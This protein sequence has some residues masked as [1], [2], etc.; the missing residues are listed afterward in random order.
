M[1]MNTLRYVVVFVA[2]LGASAA[3]ATTPVAAAAPQVAEQ[4]ILQRDTV[5]VSADL[6]RL[7]D[8]FLN[9][10]DAKAKT[11]VAYAPA[12]GRR[13]LFDARWLYRVAHRHGLGWRPAG[14][15]DQV[16]VERESTVVGRDDVEQQILSAL[17]D[18]GVD[19][20][21]A[22]VQLSNRMF[23][24]HLPA[25]VEPNLN[26]EDVAF[27]A[28]RGHFDAVVTVSA[29]G[30]AE[31]RVRVTG[32]LH[33]MV[34]VPVLAHRIAAGEVLAPDDI[35]WITVRGQTLQKHS[36]L[37]AEDLVGLTPKRTLRPGVPISTADVQR[38][39]MVSKGEIIVIA[40][41]TPQMLLSAR[42]QALNNGSKGDVI[43]IANTQSRQIVEAVVT[44]PGQATV[45][46]S[47]TAPLR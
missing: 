17:A 12:P 28:R 27:D 40:L 18:R 29:D 9:V 37:A 13:A 36:I 10:S 2:M 24:L 5:I 45:G 1:F 16:T 14:I 22:K 44:G 32:Q 25:D 47:F 39:I 15:H 8:L 35:R 26:V 3:T 21:Q 4:A 41:Q 38:P 43:R 33:E 20:A 11:P 31:Q 42:G 19:T 6:V 34:D 23:R 46:A 7:G 30:A